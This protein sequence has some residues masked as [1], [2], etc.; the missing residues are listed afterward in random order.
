VGNRD[1]VILLQFPTACFLQQ[2]TWQDCHIGDISI[3]IGHGSIYVRGYVRMA[4]LV[5]ERIL[6]HGFAPHFYGAKDD[7]HSCLGE[8]DLV[9]SG[10]RMERDRSILKIR[11]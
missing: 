8:W 5:L 11:M 3:P 10:F 7:Y 9:R 4:T 2:Y 1:K 6:E